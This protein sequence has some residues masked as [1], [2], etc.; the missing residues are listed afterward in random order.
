MMLSYALVT[1]VRSERENLL[2]LADSL[3]RQTVP[4]AAWLVVDNG[5]TDGSIEAAREL[6]ARLPWVQV[7]EIPGDPTPR[8]GAP[9]VRAFHAGLR[10]LAVETDVVVKLDA[11]VSLEPDYFQRQL[12]E[13]VA[14]PTLGIAS[15]ACLELERGEWRPVDVTEGH[16]RGA[17]RAYRRP[18]LNDVLPL[19]EA[20]GWDGL[21]GVKAAMRGWTTR[22]IP[23]LAFYHHRALGQRDGSRTARW[24]AQGRACWFM[25]YRPGYLVLR[26]VHRA[27]QNPGALAMVP[28]YFG[29]ALRREPRYDD[30]EVRRYLRQKQSLA[31]A[32][33]RARAA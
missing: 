3:E 20:V 23:G 21:D 18:C 30:P 31:A 26:T 15:G 16:V 11:D 10:E 13:F 22:T 5:S 24:K 6:S 29:A 1:P 27:R 9:I 28:G 33:R 32:L 19:A 7:L 14:N 12:A 2:R 8:P 17:V 4:P 25:G